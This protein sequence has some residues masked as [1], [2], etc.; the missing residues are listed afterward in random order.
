MS[1]SAL[2]ALGL[3]ERAR[4]KQKV[5]D[6]EDLSEA[7][8]ASVVDE[9]PAAQQTAIV[10]AV[11]VA[12]T[13]AAASTR[14][15]GAIKG[16]FAN[17]SA[18]SRGLGEQI[19]VAQTYI[20]SDVVLGAVLLSG[21]R[22]F[23]Y[24]CQMTQKVTMYH[25]RNIFYT[26]VA[27]DQNEIDCIQ[28]WIRQQASTHRSSVHAV[29]RDEAQLDYIGGLEQPRDGSPQNMADQIRFTRERGL[30]SGGARTPKVVFAPGN[31][32]GVGQSAAGGGGGGGGGIPVKV[33]LP[34]G[35]TRC[36]W[37]WAGEWN[38][39]PAEHQH[40]V[41]GGAEPLLELLLA[42]LGLGGGTDRGRAQQ[43]TVLLV[44]RDQTKGGN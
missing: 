3:R 39:P 11:V 30:R 26:H 16:A 7:A 27:L 15:R 37:L 10:V 8:S 23:T 42:G 17:L 13:A 28:K 33:T 32:L 41:G 36:V 35:D 12:A 29:V 4:R 34:D 25:I 22:T 24:A 31:M 19:K 43:V 20:R 1:A 40:E 2:V 5:E 21:L 14:G 6:D 9:P 38:P 44:H 18:A